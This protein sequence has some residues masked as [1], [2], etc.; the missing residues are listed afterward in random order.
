MDQYLEN[1]GIALTAFEDAMA[2]CKALMNSNHA[3][4]ITREEDLW[5]VN[6]VWCESG[7]P[8]RN[9]VVFRCRSSVDIEEYEAAQRRRAEID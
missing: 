3:V 1:D 4:M 7:Y 5:I 6:W 8:N 9:D 2:V